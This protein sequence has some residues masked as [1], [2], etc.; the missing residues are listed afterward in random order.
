MLT[1]EEEQF[2]K[3]WEVRRLQK[4][5]AFNFTL[6]LPL[7]VVIV[8]AL[9]VNILTGWHKQAAMAIQKNTSVI[10]VVLIAAVAIVVF[11]TVFSTHYQREQNEQR[12]QELLAKKAAAE[13]EDNS[14]NL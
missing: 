4:K 7:G 6:G 1:K 13:K 14:S 8:L 12:Y 5:K 9:F 11:M 2:L 10:L 3:D